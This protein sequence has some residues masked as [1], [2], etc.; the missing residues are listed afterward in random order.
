L[1]SSSGDV[2]N[3]W[4]DIIPIR[5]M[6][7]SRL[8]IIETIYIPVIEKNPSTLPDCHN[9]VLFLP[10]GRGGSGGERSLRK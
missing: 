2:F 6:I 7:L 4:L 1:I 5:N 3:E 8:K 10:V 9:I